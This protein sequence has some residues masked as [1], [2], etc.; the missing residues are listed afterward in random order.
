MLRA[1]GEPVKLPVRLLTRA[2]RCWL[3]SSH[4]R[5]DANPA[6]DTSHHHHHPRSDRSGCGQVWGDLAT[7][8]PTKQAEGDGAELEQ[9]PA[10]R[11]GRPIRPS[12]KADRARSPHRGLSHS[13]RT[14][15]KATSE[16]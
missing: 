13:T 8:E 2:R 4:P 16:K 1:H 14:Q 9:G 5:S 7:A 3:C 11:L 15:Y 10:A 6:E 12:L